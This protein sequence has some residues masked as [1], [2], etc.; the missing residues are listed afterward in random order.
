MIKKTISS[1]KDIFFSYLTLYFTIILLIIIYIISTNN[2][3]IL[4]NSKLLYKYSLIAMTITIIPITIFLY[5]KN[6]HQSSPINK[7]LLLLMIPLGVTISL[8]YNNLTITFKEPSILTTKNIIIIILYTS[9]I[10]PIF[11][12]ILFRY[13][14]YNKLKDIYNS[15]ISILITTTIFSLLHQGLISI[16]Y[17]FILGL[18]LSYIYKKTQNILYPITIHIFANF[19]S[20]FIT[21]YQPIVLIL[22]IT[23]L[24]ITIYLI[25]KHLVCKKAK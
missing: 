5:K 23:I 6:Y 17:A 19:A 3:D 15:N 1:L 20:I 4:N 9:I 12:E 10:G 21:S 11:E 2:L 14:T 13:V 25:K 18:I 22:S 24:L 8:I 16:A 7:K